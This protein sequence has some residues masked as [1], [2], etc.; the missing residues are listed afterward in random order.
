MSAPIDV[1][2]ARMGAQGDGI[3]EGPDG[4]VFVPY[5]LPGERVRG[6]LKGE[7]LEIE[8]VLEASPER[9]EPPCSHF[10]RCGGCLLQHWQ[11]EPYFA[12]KRALVVEALAR[13]GI[14]AQ[15][16]P[17]VDAHGAGRRR[18]I[19]HARQ[20]GAR[21][22][23]GFAERRSHAMVPIE[24]C[25]VLAPSLADALPAARAVAQALAP[26]KKPLDIQ[27]TESATGLDLDVR[28]SGPL[29]PAQFAEVAAI[30]ERF[31]LARLTRHGEL[32]LQRAAPVALMGRAPVEL[33]PAAF[34][35]ATAEG[36]AVLS[37]RVRDATC[38]A[39]RVADLFAGVGTFALRLAEAHRVAA[40]ESHAGAMAA[41]LK[42]G[43][44]TPG[45]K[46]IEGEA[47]DLFRRPL[48]AKELAAFDAVVIDPPRQG[49][50][51]QARE[52][53]QSPVPRL[54][55]VSCN[56]ATFARDARLLLDGGFRLEGVTPVD[57]FRYSPHVELVG[58]FRR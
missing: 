50:E 14:V 9:A 33:P 25:P 47:R 55:Y 45:L 53:A 6:V 54:V 40:Y 16:A 34:L 21:T 22:V 46:G 43:K 38:G 29:P 26:L 56:V 18:V 51:A 15:V 32:V 41:L 35:Q 12:F 30:A 37:A 5:A 8:A 36:E 23:V 3:A 19:L 27:V 44:A 28:G 13:E 7:R 4:P 52:L 1:A 58:L 39:K 24:A 31:R 48:M 57:Q 49:A 42:A 10:G 17:L 20:Y 11:L 2:I